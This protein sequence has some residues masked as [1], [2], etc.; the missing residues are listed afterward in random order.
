MFA[1]S[2]FFYSEDGNYIMFMFIFVCKNIKIMKRFLFLSEYC[3]AE[4]DFINNS[5]FVK[6]SRCIPLHKK[7]FPVINIFLL[8][9]VLSSMLTTRIIRLYRLILLGGEKKSGKALVS[10]PVG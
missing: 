6:Y 4:D 9:V 5:N 8:F 10:G 7:V 1:L 2:V 3:S